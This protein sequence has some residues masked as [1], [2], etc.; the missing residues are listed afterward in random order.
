MPTRAC[1]RGDRGRRRSARPSALHRSARRPITRPVP[2]SRMAR[3][4]ACPPDGAREHDRAPLR[5]RA[6]ARRAAPRARRAARRRGRPGHRLGG[7]ARPV[8]GPRRDHPRQLRPAARRD[9]QGPV[10]RPPAGRPCRPRWRRRWSSLEPAR[11]DRHPGRAAGADRR[12]RSSY[13]RAA[14]SQPTVGAAQRRTA[15]A[16]ARWPATRSSTTRYEAVPY[17][18][19]GGA[20]LFDRLMAM[21]LVNV[22]AVRAHRRCSRG[23]WRPRCSARARA[24]RGDARDR[25]VALWPMLDVHGRRREPRH[26]AVDRV[27]ARG[28][29]RR[30]PR[31]ARPDAR[32]ACVALCLAGAACMLVHG[33]GARRRRSWSS[34]RC[35]SPVVRFRPPLRAARRAGRPPARRSRPS[36]LLRLARRCRPPAAGGGLYGG[37]ADLARTVQPAQLVAPD[38]AV[39]LR[40][41]LVHGAAARARTTATARWSSSAGSSAC[42]AAWR[43]R[44]RRGST[45]S[46]STRSSLLL[47]ARVDRR[48]P[49]PRPAAARLAGARGAR[50]ARRS[51]LHAAAAHRVLPRADRRRRTRSSPAATCCR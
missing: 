38:V 15:S 39:L 7:R 17:L 35:S 3:S 30:A 36:P 46:C 13:W 33:R 18:V 32:R 5:P 19:L 26:R 20:D 10:V 25:L 44:T 16:R 22:A 4:I 2:A 23:C 48:G 8:P 49:P 14:R 31:P 11:D 41:A 51:A 21:R 29:A 6:R 1:A 43:S 50:D 27:H 9:R 24:L 47:L 12:S 37:E 28:A 45:T 42:S 34:P 40:P